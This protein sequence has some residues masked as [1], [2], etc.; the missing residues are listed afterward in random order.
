MSTDC[1]AQVHSVKGFA[2]VDFDGGEFNSVVSL[3]VPPFVWLSAVLILC[4]FAGKVLNSSPG[5]LGPTQPR[6]HFRTFRGFPV[7]LFMVP[8]GLLE[9]A[10]LSASEPVADGNPEAEAEVAESTEVTAGG[11]TGFNWADA[12]EDATVLTTDV[13]VGGAASSALAEAEDE[14]FDILRFDALSLLDPPKQEEVT[15][16][17]LFEALEAEADPAAEPVDH[18]IASDPA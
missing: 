10:A 17:E 11:S 8:E 4:S 7:S 12:S 16:E 18:P 15:A 5:N 3:L 13:Q 14:D 1:M 9:E 6:S 2:L